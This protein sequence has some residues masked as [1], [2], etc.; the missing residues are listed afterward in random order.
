MSTELETVMSA[1]LRLS[2]SDRERLADHLLDS[3]NAPDSEAESEWANEIR[4]RLDDIRSGRVAA[5]P[6]A[7]A[8]AFYMDDGDGSA[9]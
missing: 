8:R 3:L 9:R 2:E 1:A 7:E 5:V 4:R 6:A